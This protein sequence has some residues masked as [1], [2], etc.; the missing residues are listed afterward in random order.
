[1]Y[2]QSDEFWLKPYV[3]ALHFSSHTRDRVAEEVKTPF[4]RCV[5]RQLLF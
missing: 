4:Q 5:G 2:V 1:M 3:F